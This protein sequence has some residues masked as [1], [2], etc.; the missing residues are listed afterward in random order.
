VNVSLTSL[1]IYD[2]DQD[3]KI[4]FSQGLALGIAFK[5]GN[6]PVKK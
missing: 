3:N 1:M 2:L 6:F 5:R 4:Q